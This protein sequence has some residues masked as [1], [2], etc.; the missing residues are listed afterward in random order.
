MRN[1]QSAKLEMDE[2]CD[3][4]RQ[5]SPKGKAQENVAPRSTS[6]EH[7]SRSI[8]RGRTG[9]DM[10]RTATE[11]SVAAAAAK[12]AAELVAAAAAKHAAELVAA[13]AAKHAAELVAA[14]AREAERVAA[15]AREAKRVAAA[16]AAREAER[17]AAATAQHTA[18][19][20]A[21]A[22]REAQ[23]VAAATAERVA[24]AA[25]QREAQ[26]VATAARE[27][28]LVAA[29]TEARVAA[30]V[31]A[32]VAQREEEQHAAA[33]VAAAEAQ[34]EAALVAVNAE[35]APLLVAV[36]PAMMQCSI[37]MDDFLQSDGFMCHCDAEATM[38]CRDCFFGA[39]ERAV[40]GDCQ[41]P[42]RRIHSCRA[43][44]DWSVPEILDKC[45][46]DEIPRVIAY[47]NGLC[48]LEKKL[49]MDKLHEAN[50]FVD[51]KTK[52]MAEREFLAKQAV[53]DMLCDSCPACG[54]KNAGFDD[55]MSV[56]CT[57]C[58]DKNLNALNFCAWCFQFIGT[59]DEV[60]THLNFCECRLPR[61][62]LQTQFTFGRNGLNEMAGEIYK[63]KN[64]EKL[65]TKLE[66]EVSR[67]LF[68]TGML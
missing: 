51:D 60:H 45:L 20:V 50:Y 39:M 32:A 48:Q 66:P 58:K 36:E 42:Q 56:S 9:Y 64:V 18:E 37:C 55:C 52:P 30:L 43:C 19:L 2:K 53:G 47:V 67:F 61:I 57:V 25:A 35:V 31:A 54:V 40:A 4:S 29:A 34:H 62:P 33:L 10:S 46:K 16:T 8:E 24:A 3:Q 65:L 44:N 1:E 23:R 28:A 11:T 41:D 15:A 6:T 22:A 13:A 27:A 59:S 38:N 63:M 17:V 21:A 5:T 14:A 49:L 26:L 68:L 7:G 12:H